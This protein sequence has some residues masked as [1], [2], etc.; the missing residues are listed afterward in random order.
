MEFTNL[1]KD[2]LQPCHSER[3]EDLALEGQVVRDSWP[4]RLL[5]ITKRHTKVQKPH[6]Y[7]LLSMSHVFTAGSLILPAWA[8]PLLQGVPPTPPIKNPENEASKAFR[9][10]K[11]VQKRAKNEANRS[12]K[13]IL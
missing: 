5:A 8:W 12:Q 2:V 9:I 13:P 4:P 10:S 3:V 11:T 6:G 1:V 7:C